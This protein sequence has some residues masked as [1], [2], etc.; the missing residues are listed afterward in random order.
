MTPPKEEIK[1]PY[2]NRLAGESSPYLLQHAHNPVDWYPWGEEAFEKALREDKPVLVS[3]GYAACHWCHVMERE[4]F[5][6]PE[7]ASIMNEHFVNIKVDREE[8]PDVDHIYMDAVQAMSGSGGWPLNVFLTP[9][10]RPFYGGTYF[11]PRRAFNR[12]SWREVLVSLSQAYKGSREE[13]EQQARNLTE[14]LQVSNAFGTALAGSGVEGVKID[15]AV[16][17]IFKA[18]DREWGGFGRAPKFPQ[19]FTISFLLRHAHSSGDKASLAQA[20]LSLDKMIQG[21]I[22][23]QAGGGFARYSTD[24]EWLAP[25]FEKMLYDNALL[26]S[27]LSEAFQLTGK[28]VYGEVIE[29]TLRFVE[30]E[31]MHPGGGF[32]SALDA[33]SEGEEGKFY[34]WDHAEAVDLLG[35]DA[36][37][38]CRYFDITPQGNWEG[39]SILRVKTPLEDFALASGIEQE[40]LRAVIERGKA[41]LMQVR[42]GRIRPQLDDKVLLGWNALMNTAYSKAYAATGD[43]HYKEVAER[44][45]KF[46]LSAFEGE[47][48]LMLHTWKEGRAKHPAFLDDYGCLIAALLELAQVTA[49]YSYLDRASALTDTVLAHFADEQSPFLFYTHKG[50]NDVLIRKKEIY[51]GATPSGNALM[52][53][54]LH[55]LSMYYDKAEWRERAGAMVAS[56]A[57]VVVKYPTS[58]GLWLGLLSEMIDGA[59]EIA[60]LGKEWKNYLEK[61]L[62][63]YIS[64]KL[65]MAS[66]NPL[67]KYPLLA[68][69]AQSSEI[70]IY[71]CKNYACRQPVTTIQDLVSLLQH[72]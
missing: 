11:P 43:P 69:K 32:Y 47:G 3:I 39:H 8:R 56:L 2:S 34:V 31:L 62:R 16:K 21:G 12:A 71:L 42:A 53:A 70:L 23:D 37:L 5:E 27:V 29:E 66:E 68:D 49:D 24:T 58:F 28:M 10:K 35:E 20:L 18:A 44:N 15:V 33:D 46:L 48:G 4:S 41:K 9:D 14:H 25:H 52:A 40:E 1:P 7:V 51:D 26:V 50:Q 67:P 59:T 6:D 22:Y 55:R 72:K 60:I 64:H 17:N 54:N 30:R 38:F 19:T 65:A 13:V 63:M 45:M 57:D 61:I 36:A